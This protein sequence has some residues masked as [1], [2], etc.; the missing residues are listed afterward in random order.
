MILNIPLAEA[1]KVKDGEA[2]Y[3]IKQVLKKKFRESKLTDKILTRKDSEIS[4][5]ILSYSLFDNMHD[6]LDSFDFKLF[7]V[8]NTKEDVLK[9]YRNLNGTRSPKKWKTIVFKLKKF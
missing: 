1:N 6:A 5:E 7:N 8:G 4:F 9:Y 2:F 3:T